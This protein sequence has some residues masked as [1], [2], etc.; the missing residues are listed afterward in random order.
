M[1]QIKPIMVTRSL[2]WAM[3]AMLV[4]IEPKKAAQ[5]SQNFLEVSFSFI[6]SPL[7]YRCA[8]C[9][10]GLVDTALDGLDLV[11]SIAEDSAPVVSTLICAN[12]SRGD[13]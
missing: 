9:V 11:I 1:E 8:V 3:P 13:V 7:G 12:Q 4:P 2:P 5:A 6:V 10:V